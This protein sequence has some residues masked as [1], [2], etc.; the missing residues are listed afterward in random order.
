M[1]EKTQ[2]SWT[3]ST[4]PVVAGCMK[5]S[6]AC[7]N[8]Y[9]IRDSWRMG[10]NPN[11]KIRSAYEGMAVSSTCWTG[12]V[13]PLPERL[14]WPLRWRQARKIFVCN[15][16]DLF[17][18]DVPD[19]FL[20]K[21]FAVIALAGMTRPRPTGDVRQASLHTFQVLTKRPERML[22]Y[23]SDPETPNRL[24]HSARGL[25]PYGDGRTVYEGHLRAPGRWPQAELRLPE[26]PLPWLWLGVTAETQEQAD[27][28]IPLLLQVPAAVR[29]VSVEPMLGPIRLDHMDADAA[30]H[31]EWCWINALTGRQTDMG[32]PCP[33]VPHLDWVICGGESGPHARPMHPDWARDL[34]DQCQAAGVPFFFK[35]WGEWLPV[36]QPW[37]Q[38]SPE[39]LAGN[40]RWLNLAGGHGFHGQE[41]WRMRCVGKKVAGDLLDAQEWHQFPVARN[42]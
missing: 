17:H 9:A 11:P 29:F 4:W 12:V 10:H 26:W 35:Q 33:D 22:S 3:D 28:R 6:P 32:R 37:K 8:C 25:D 27:K 13:R 5:V 2:I 30:G 36:D 14:D 18:E 24:W 42:G 15:L 20:D 38:T 40:E 41:V 1:G 21:V 31:K 7:Q 23:L 34:R 39:R 19:A 16:S